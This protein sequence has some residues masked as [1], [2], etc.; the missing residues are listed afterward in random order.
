MNKYYPFQVWAAT[1]ICGPFLGIILNIVRRPDSFEIGHLLAD[2][3]FLALGG[4]FASLPAFAF[5]Y[6]SYRFLRQKVQSE[7][8]FKLI[9][10][11]VSILC[12]IFTVY[13]FVSEEMFQP[14]NRDG[15]IILLSY[16]FCALLAGIYFRINKHKYY[17]R[18]FPLGNL[19]E[20]KV[21]HK[22]THINNDI[23][24]T[25]EDVRYIL[26]GN[27]ID[28]HYYGEEKTIKSGTK[29]FRAGAKVYLFPEYGGMGHETMP[30]YG[31]PRKSWKKLKL[32]FALC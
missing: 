29:Q 18:F 26:V 25:T 7:F 31:L 15:F 1:L 27:I 9:L 10:C 23:S 6:L 5:Y 11:P 19:T 20:A 13:F 28:K 2:P 3:I 32:L 8:Y 14:S 17:S 21:L 24:N 12:L 22:M 30:I 16:L 4:A